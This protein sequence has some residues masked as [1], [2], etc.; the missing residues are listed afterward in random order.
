MNKEMDWD[1]QVPEPIAQKWNAW[2]ED[3]FVLEKT[4]A[5]PRYL[6][7]SKLRKAQLHVFCDASTKA[8]AACVYVRVTET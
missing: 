7:F 2:L 6:G 8:F 5:Y 4:I 1:T 3:L